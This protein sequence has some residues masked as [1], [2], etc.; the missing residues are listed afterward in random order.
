[1]GGGPLDVH[2]RRPV[3]PGV[4]I[5]ARGPRP[6]LR[7]GLMAAV[8]TRRSTG[9]LPTAV[10][11]IGALYCLFPVSWVL[12]AA[13][14]S[15]GELFTTPTMAFG[16]GFFANVSDLL[17][18]RD[19]VFWLWLVNTFVYAGGGSLLATLV[20]AVSGFALAKYRFPGRTLIFNLLIGGIL[21]PAVVLAIPQYLLFS[22]VGLADTYGAGRLP[23]IL[24]P[25]SIYLARVY[26]TAAIPDSLLEA[27]RIDGAGEWTLRSRVALPLMVPGMVT[28]FLF[29]FVAIWNNFLLPYIMLG[30]DGKF[31]LT[32]GL[33]TL[34]AAG[35]N[36]P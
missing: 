14:K 8:S 16:T 27:G 23:Q 3:R 26:A 18:Y 7:G 15:P 6:R 34:L 36:Q 1:L 4:R 22:E 12:I 35:A 30:D 21:V 28:I 25:Y 20:A 32:V 2:R 17:A 33:Y 29:Q 31:P 10:L 13:T 9:L 19:G 5:S 11:L 24:S